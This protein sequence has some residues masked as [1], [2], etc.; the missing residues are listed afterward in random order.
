[1]RVG[2][3]RE[4]ETGWQRERGPVSDPLGVIVV[5]TDML[6]GSSAALSSNV[7]VAAVVPQGLDI[8]VGAVAL[9]L[10]VVMLLD[11][12]ALRRVASGAAIAEYVSLVMA[13]VLC[14]AA[15]VLSEWLV[16]FLPW[17]DVTPQAELASDLLVIAAMAFFALYFFRVRRAM[18]RF[19]NR[20]TEE[21]AFVRAQTQAPSGGLGEGGEAPDPE[22]ADG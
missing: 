8:G 1:M 11:V 3:G 9:V 2:L 18:V 19:L 20:F 12:L 21:E 4:S 14:L 7:A 6:R 10:A 17:D 16:R 13:A 15:S 22:A 5:A